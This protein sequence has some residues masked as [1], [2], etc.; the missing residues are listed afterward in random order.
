MKMEDLTQ[1]LDYLENA[2]IEVQHNEALTDIQNDIE[3]VI[4]DVKSELEPLQL[5]ENEYETSELNYENDCYE[6]AVL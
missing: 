5:L 1:A 2:L 4:K 6:R 3:E